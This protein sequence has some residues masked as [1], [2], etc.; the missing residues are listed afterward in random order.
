MTFFLMFWFLTFWSFDVLIILKKTFNVLTL[1]CSDFWRSDPLSNHYTAFT[2]KKVYLAN[3]YSKW[4][5]ISQLCPTF[6]INSEN[7]I[8]K[9]ICH[10][11]KSQSWIFKCKNKPNPNCS[12]KITTDVEAKKY[13]MTDLMFCLRNNDRVGLM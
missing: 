13:S 2:W 9:H 6:S 7:H 3:E 8:C 4:I 5:A 1:W 12:V 11:K 10:W